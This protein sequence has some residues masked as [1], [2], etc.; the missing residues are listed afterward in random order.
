MTLKFDQYHNGIDTN[1]L[2]IPPSLELLTKKQIKQIVAVNWF[3]TEAG[4]LLVNTARLD[5]EIV[6]ECTSLED[7]D[8]SVDGEILYVDDCLKRW[9]IEDGFYHT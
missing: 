9:S 3:E 1:L 6:E 5:D 7:A 2:M 4:D 8:I